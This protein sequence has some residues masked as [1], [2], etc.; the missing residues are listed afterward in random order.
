MKRKRFFWL[1]LLIGA[2]FFSTS[3]LAQVNLQ[4]WTTNAEVVKL[5][6][7]FNEQQN[8]IEIQ[9]R[10]SDFKDLT[11]DALRAYAIKKAP[12]I[13]AID[14]PMHVAFSSK[15]AF[16]D[17]TDRIAKSEVIDFSKIYP[18]SRQTVMW[19]EKIYGLPKAVN[20]LC[21]YYN[22]DMFRKA[23]LDPDSP[24]ETWSQLYEYAKKLTDPDKKVYGFAF[25]A[26]ATGEGVFQFLP[27]VQMAG[28]DYDNLASPEAAEALRY[29]KRF[30][31]EGLSSKSVLTQRQWDMTGEF[32]AG[33]HAMIVGGP[34]ELPRMTKTAEFDWGVALLPYNDKKKTR[35]SALGDFNYAIFNTTKHPDDAFKVIEF[36]HSQSDRMWNEFGRLSPR[37]DMQPDKPRWPE[38]HAVFAKQME[39]A[40]ARGPHPNWPKVATAIHEAFQKV[41]TGQEEPEAA[42]AEAAK[43]IKKYMK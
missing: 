24:P 35:A 23:G 8:E 31:D 1:W 34:W 17:L 30:I 28:A 3:A 13:I 15:G 5:A 6:E 43:R 12:D 40:R 42:L 21:L 25:S 2:I 20:T 38:V 29:M 41:Y 37:S 7:E 9:I 26:I 32:N 36:L 22:K 10:K 27:W 14:N 4:L 16:L 39:T 18:G 19:H 33:R 11:T